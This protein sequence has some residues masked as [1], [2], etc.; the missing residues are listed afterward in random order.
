MTAVVDP[1]NT[2][3]A[4][5]VGAGSND[6][7]P[8]PEQQAEDRLRGTLQK[9]ARGDLLVVVMSFIFAF[10]IGSVL[11]VIADTEV[12]ETFSYF[13]D[14]PSDAFTAIWQSVT[15]AYGAMFR[16][17]VFDG[18]GYSRVA[19]DLRAAGG[20]GTYVLL[21]ALAAGLRPL[22]ETLT[23]ATPLIIA[24]AGMAVSF[25]AGLFNIGG[26]G[27]LIVG[28]MAAGYIG[29]TWDLPIVVHLLIA[30]LG[31]LLAGAVWGGIA[32]FLK[33]RFGANEVISTIML[34]W[35]A[36][37][38]LFFALKTAAFTGA[39]QSQ[40]TSPSISD[41]AVLPQLLGSGFRLHAGLFLAAGAAVLLW[42]LMSRSTL[43]F[44][45]RAVGSNPRASRV[46]GISPSRTAFLVLTV[47]GGLVGLAG[48][49]HVL[50][51][52]KRLTEGVAGSIGFDA[53]TVALL[54]RSGPVGVVLA[55][56]LF[57]G[58]ST[59]GRFMESS[60]GVP[61]DLVQVI[62]VLVVLF[63]AAPPLVR[64]L[65]GLRRVDHPSTGAR[66]RTARRTMAGS[67]ST[68]AS[69]SDSTSISDS[70]ST[71]TTSPPSASSADPGTSAAGD[72]PPGS[73]PEGSPGRSPDPAGRHEG[74]HR[75]PSAPSPDAPSS[76]SSP[77]TAPPA[78]DVEDPTDATG[79]QR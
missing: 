13:L 34:N 75:D 41:S 65:I 39:N 59:G 51:T 52:E 78:G 20:S 27:Q 71:S 29:F 22:T 61:L 26:T 64:T 30:L 6:A 62:Q 1:E 5:G 17:A 72:L 16:G 21:P 11:I 45:F 42:W 31:G 12:R 54:G 44:Q 2:S 23:V 56:L 8:P 47:A 40:P 25:R 68:S 7:P 73:T 37:Y 69:N 50:G 18:V 32:G 3:S 35:I 55:G 74:A 70:M 46:A 15:Q 58:L 53:I 60:Q 24:A 33:A 10:L 63:I 36:T 66:G 79:D 77:R 4:P 38:L 57:A 19:D 67:T 9:I 43:G 76:D 28:A 49:V 14:R 48:A